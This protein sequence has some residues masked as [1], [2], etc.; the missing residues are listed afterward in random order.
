VAAVKKKKIECDG[1]EFD[2]NEELEFYHWVKEAEQYK[3]IS[4]FKYNCESYPLAPKQTIPVEK[5][6]K[7]KTKI[8]D[9]HLFHEHSYKPDFHLFKG[10]RWDVL[11]DHGLLSTHSFKNEFI[12]DIKGSFQLHDG[13]RSF[14]INQKWMFDRHHIY[15]NKVVPE[16]FFKLTWIPEKCRFSPKKKQLRKKYATIPTLMEKYG[17]LKP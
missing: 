9:K 4:G 1:I 6:L 3:I 2:S 7:T 14:S 10:E 15:I 8:V 5:K 11:E 17:N 13:A 12:I 16:K